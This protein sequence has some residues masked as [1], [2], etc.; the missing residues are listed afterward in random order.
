MIGSACEAGELYQA[1]LRGEP[2]AAIARLVD[3]YD[4]LEIQ[5]IGNNAF[6]IKKEDVSAVE[7]EEDL[8]EI[9]RRIVKLGEQFHKPV[10]ATCDVHFM[11]PQDEIYR[12]II[13]TGKGFDDAD[14]QA[15]LF[16]RTTEEMLEEFSYLGS[17]KAEEV[18]IT[19]PR[20]ISD[21]V[22]KISPIRAGKFRR[23]SKIP[24]RHCV[25]SAT[26]ARM[27]STARSCRR[28]FPRASSE[29]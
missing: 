16:L 26:T 15:P 21:L 10:V 28:S 12:R 5:P 13:M 20:K 29:S 27:K 23:S 6:M 14:E 4:Y 3:F 18:V 24:T 1:I 9:N 11:D 25:E 7:S 22:E 8:K 19:N 17:E 2:D